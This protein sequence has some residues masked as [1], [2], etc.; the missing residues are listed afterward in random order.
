MDPRRGAD[1]KRVGPHFHLRRTTRCEWVWL[2]YLEQDQSPTSRRHINEE[3][4][5]RAAREPMLASELK[6]EF[7]VEFRKKQLRQ[8]VWSLTPFLWRGT[9]FCTHSLRPAPAHLA[10]YDA[11]ENQRTGGPFF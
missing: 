6:R 7:R 10:T 1:G 4:M 5:T 3:A 11:E 8:R 9:R 2:A